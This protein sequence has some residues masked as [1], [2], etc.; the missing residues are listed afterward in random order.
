MRKFTYLRKNF[1]L[2]ECSVP[3]EYVPSFKKYATR[4]YKFN[5][6][7]RNPTPDENDQDLRITWDPVTDAQNLN[8]LS[9]SYELTKGR[10]P[11]H[12]RMLLFEKLYQNNQ[13]LRT[14]IH[15]NDIGI[16]W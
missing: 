7:Y 5:F 9:I 2:K 11:F 14:L 16:K 13:L 4:I 15:F 12:E 1:K 6:F 10:N 3:S 8:Y